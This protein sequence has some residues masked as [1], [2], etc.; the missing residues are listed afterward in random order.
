MMLMGHTP[1]VE[2][3]PLTGTAPR[4]APYTGVRPE[5]VLGSDVLG[6]SLEICD[7]G[8]D[9]V[10]G[11]VG[12][13]E[14]LVIGAV[15]DR[16]RDVTRRLGDPSARACATAAGMNST[17]ATNTAGHAARL[18]ID[19]VVHT[20]RRA[21]AS[22]GERLDHR[23][24]V[25]RD[26]LAQVGRRGLGEGGLAVARHARRR[27]RAAA[28]RRGPG[29][30]R[31]APSRCRAGRCGGPATAS[32]GSRSRCAGARSLVGSRNR[33][34][35]GEISRITGALPTAPD[36][37]PPIIAEKSPAPPPQCRRAAAARRN[38]GSVALAT[39]SGSPSAIPPAPRTPSPGICRRA[40]SRPG[41]APSPGPAGCAK[42]RPCSGPTEQDGVEA[43][44]EL[45]MVQRPQVTTPS[46][47]P[48][49]PRDRENGRPC[50]R[51]LAVEPRHRIGARRR[52]DVLASGT[53]SGEPLGEAERAACPGC[54][55]SR[56][57][58]R[59]AARR[60]RCALRA[61]A[62]GRSWRWRGCPGRGR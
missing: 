21:A 60:R 8:E 40:A 1:S 6:V 44:H 39:L 22:I 56:G 19:R 30:R 37:Q 51:T 50:R 34:R 9:V 18:E 24:A 36:A 59:P 61:A 58:P 35:H 49:D 28:L 57:R 25:H 12:D 29:T 55:A 45:G 17:V 13:R 2:S 10:V 62:P 47:A 26:L 43:E 16:V 4:S 7:G 14:H 38:F 20:A 42:I 5:S 15:L 53:S 32:R 52:A 27:A 41:P 11:S 54:R 48:A 23:V 33:A 46:I 31:R 3:G